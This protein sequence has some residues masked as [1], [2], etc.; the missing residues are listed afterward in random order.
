MAGQRSQLQA[1]MHCKVQLPL[2]PAFITESLHQVLC[3]QWL[4]GPSWQVHAHISEL[5]EHTALRLIHL[6]FQLEVRCH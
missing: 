1:P 4:G 3:H 2:L 5:P 6:C